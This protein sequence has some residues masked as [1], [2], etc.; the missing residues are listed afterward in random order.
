MRYPI[1]KEWTAIL[2]AACHQIHGST[3]YLETLV[4]EVADL[5]DAVGWFMPRHRYI[6]A[7]S[8][9]WS[10][11]SHAARWD[12]GRHEISHALAYDRY[13]ARGLGHGSA[14]I[15][16]MNRFGIDE[17]RVDLRPDDVR[18]RDAFMSAISCPAT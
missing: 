16:C 4:I 9:T 3:S 8:V 7:S 1:L 6:G 14:W 5:T 18:D 10:H 2:A 17:P 15:R 13:G 12:L 11:L